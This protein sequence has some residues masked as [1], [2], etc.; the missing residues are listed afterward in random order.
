VSKEKSTTAIR[1]NRIFDGQHWHAD[2]AV[3]VSDERISGIYR[4]AEIPAGAEV[5]GP[6][7]LLAPGFI[8]VQVNG[9]GGALFNASPTLDC[10]RTI[11]AGHRATGTTGMMPTVVSDDREIAEAAV[12]AVRTLQAEGEP[13]LLGIHMEGPYLAPEKR[14]VHAESK[15]RALDEDD[16]S[17]LISLTDLRVL[18]TVAPEIVSAEQI[19]RLTQAGIIVSGGHSQASFETTR[20][21]IDAGLTG[22]T[23]LFNAMP[24]VSA[25]EPGIL[26][27]A[28]TDR[29]TWAGIIADGHHVHP[30]NIRLAVA[31]K[32]PDRIMLV[33][34]AMPTVGA[35]NPSFQLYRET[36]TVE[37]GRLVNSEG[38]LAGSAIGMSEAVAYSHL[39]VGLELADCLRMASTNPARFLGMDDQLGRLTPGYR[40]D[41]VALDDDLAVSASWVAGRQAYRRDT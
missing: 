30:A 5:T 16:L 41:L 32:S 7:D 33:S 39:T 4:V 19:A 20:G 9:G 6:V 11:V 34:D 28:L 40:A 24:A 29:A 36:I 31:G 26:S 38:K 37:N 2:S 18:L 27:A 25:R 23:H 3:L 13:S 12:D 17:W 22:F 10:L 21:A 8:D 35:E 14:G 1:A 15:L